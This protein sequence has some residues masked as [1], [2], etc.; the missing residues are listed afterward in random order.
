MKVVLD[1]NV[2][3]S[4]FL[5][6]QGKPATILQLVLNHNFDICFNSA[7][8]AEYEEVLNREKFTDKIHT[9]DI[10]RFFDI[11]YEL[12]INIISTPSNFDIP[13]ETDRK[14]YDVAKTASAYLVTG[15]TKHY[16][17]EPFIITPAQFI[18]LISN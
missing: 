16:P 14:F 11:M 4:A 5:V 15:N 13:D 3:V 17:D 18:L 10:R 2:I 6:P 8:L 7:I 9:S 1:T 12:G